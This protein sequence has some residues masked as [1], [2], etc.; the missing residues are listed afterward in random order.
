MQK[1]VQD[2]HVKC[3]DLTKETCSK[4]RLPKANGEQGNVIFASHAFA[5]FSVS[6][7]CL[8]VF[9]FVLVPWRSKWKKKSK[10]VMWKW[11]DFTKET[12]LKC[13]LPRAKWRTRY[14]HLGVTRVCSNL[15]IYIMSL[16]L[17][18]VLVPCIK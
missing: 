3:Q 5:Q 8:Q 1:K 16:S 18:F 9:Y 14:R 15:G 10:I 4:C 7:W 2:R 12:R 11:Q 17:L 6:I 13:R